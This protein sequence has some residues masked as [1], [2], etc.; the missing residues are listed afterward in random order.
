MIQL[1]KKTWGIHK[2][3]GEP[4]FILPLKERFMQQIN[5]ER[6]EQA[7]KNLQWLKE[8]PTLFDEIK[9]YYVHFKYPVFPETDIDASLYINGFWSS[10]EEFFCQR[11]HAVSIKEKIKLLAQPMNPKL[12]MLALRILGRYSSDML[13]SGDAEEF[14]EYMRRVNTQSEE[15]ALIDY[16]GKKRLTPQAA[17]N[18]IALIRS[19]RI[20]DEADSQLLNDFEVYLRGQALNSLLRN[21]GYNAFL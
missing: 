2:K 19:E 12:K 4:N 1:R 20:L 9:D 16:Q 5:P 21:T 6:I 14:L 13:S 8:N 11:F 3:P 15:E 17:L 7:E 18:E 10:D